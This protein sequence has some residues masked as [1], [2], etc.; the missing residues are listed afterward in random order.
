MENK[1]NLVNYILLALIII[2]LLILLFYLLIKSLVSQKTKNNQNTNKKTLITLSPQINN[3][4]KS[5][6]SNINL[7]KNSNNPNDIINLTKDNEDLV[8]VRFTGVKEIEVDPQI[9]SEAN[10]SFEL[11]KKLPLSINGLK[12]DFNYKNNQFIVSPI[13]N[14][15]IIS[16]QEKKSFFQWL[17]ENYPDI[18]EKNIIFSPIPFISP[19]PISFPII[20]APADE[21]SDLFGALEIFFEILKTVD[22]T[23]FSSQNQ[24]QTTNSNNLYKINKINYTPPRNKYNYIFYPQIRAP[25]SD[26]QMPGGCTIGY[27]GCG[28]VT[29]AM[30]VASYRDSSVTPIDIVNEYGR[31]VNCDGSSYITAI[32]VLNKY[33]IRTGNNSTNNLLFHGTKNPDEVAPLFKHYIDA[34]QTIFA[35]GHIEVN[36][37]FWVVDVDEQNNIWAFDGV[38]GIGGVPYNHKIRFPNHYYILAFP[39]SP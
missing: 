29:V 8:S 7:N 32:N 22:S 16:D 1:N 2:F 27:S 9:A 4:K 21:K 34:G 28:P 33:G 30:I 6:S 15:R 3:L 14:S 38:Y 12:I 26:Y 20:K 25:W 35:L 18:K 11:K 37:Y 36:H 23:T 10:Q 31:S 39:V 17:K 5:T 19:T 13:K 24:N